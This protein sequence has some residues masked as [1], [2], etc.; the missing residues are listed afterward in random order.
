VRELGISLRE[1]VV[2]SGLWAWW[3]VT[4]V[5]VGASVFLE[6]V[7]PKVHI[8]DSLWLWVTLVAV[9]SG[10]FVAFHRVRLERDQM[11]GDLVPPSHG[12]ELRHELQSLVL[13]ISNQQP[14]L[15]SESVSAHFPDFD[16][17]IAEWS[18]AVERV[19]QT[20]EQL[21]TAT[22]DE[23]GCLGIGVEEYEVRFVLEYV[24]RMVHEGAMQNLLSQ[25]PPPLPWGYVADTGKLL[26]ELGHQQPPAASIPLPAPF[27]DQIG[28]TPEAREITS[29]V[30]YLLSRA[31]ES[32][33]AHELAA[34]RKALLD[35]GDSLRPLV[36]QRSRV[37]RMR[38]STDCPICR[39]NLNLPG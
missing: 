33:E 32:D 26:I 3:L 29:R 2:R 14:W 36:I 5:A 18:A 13:A 22:A 39:L 8:A 31:W 27:S 17:T 16:S 35:L 6:H 34:A 24:G 30:D 7:W 28:D 4:V 19:R 10:V 38:V 15:G 9:A 11:L 12:E 20:S 21:T 25:A 1:L 23:A 37:E